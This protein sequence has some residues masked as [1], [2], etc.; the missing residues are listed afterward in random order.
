[1]QF[2]PEQIELLWIIPAVAFAFFIF[3]LIYFAQKRE[4]QAELSQEVTRFNTGVFPVNPTNSVSGTDRLSQLEQAISSVTDSLS[5]QQ[6]AIEQ[7][8]KDSSSHN[9][10]VSELKRKLREL[11]KEYD[12]VLS[13]NYLLKAKV[14]KL[15]G[16]QDDGMQKTEQPPEEQSV[17]EPPPVEE[18]LFSKVDLKLYEDTRTMNLAVLDDTSE[19]DI[20]D[21]IPP[22]G[23]R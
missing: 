5:I 15:Q 9:G 22:Q 18:Q 3:L 7:V 20:N 17:P 2:V 6:R 21:L 12:I 1:M 19:I 10:E 11:Y 13:E 4:E 8:H 14:K 16:T 23:P